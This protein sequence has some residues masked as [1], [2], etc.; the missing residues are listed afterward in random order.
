MQ[1]LDDIDESEAERLIAEMIKLK[2]GVAVGN[3]Q[4]YV[5][6]LEKRSFSRPVIQFMIG[7]CAIFWGRVSY[8]GADFDFQDELHVISGDSSS[9]CSLS[10]LPAYSV[11][12]QHCYKIGCDWLDRMIAEY[13]SETAELR[14]RFDAGPIIGE[15]EL[16]NPILHVDA[17]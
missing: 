7:L 10:K 17:D 11:V 9:T 12:E 4:C 1:L 16:A 5:Q 3:F 14:S 13:S 6:E 2:N 8:D 15:V